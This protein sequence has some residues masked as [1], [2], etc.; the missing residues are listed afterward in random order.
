MEKHPLLTELFRLQDREYA[1]FQAK[2]LPTIPPEQIIGVRTPALQTLA[3]TWKGRAE[4]A[5]FL[6]KLPH[7]FF[8]ENQLHA[9]LIAGETDFD[10]CMAEVLRFLPYIDNWATCDQLSPKA[11]KHH[12][13]RLPEY[14]R[15][16][17]GSAQP[18]TARFAIGMLMRYFLDE[19]YAPEYPALVASVR[20]EEYY[21]N[22][23]AAWY[24]AT[25]LAKQYDAVLPYIQNNTL[26][27]WTH[28]K[29]IQK[30]LESRRITP[31]QKTYLKSLKRK[32]PRT[33]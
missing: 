5:G 33:D 6:R 20:S 21:V 18:Y 22:M 16:W 15:N 17:I 4:A 27:V 14:I 28:N 12:P 13:E 11:F 2:L 29:A 3:K 26:P 8:E 9:F 7:S 24:F 23:M 19:A 32:N 25:A 10:V 30:C 31:E 1:A